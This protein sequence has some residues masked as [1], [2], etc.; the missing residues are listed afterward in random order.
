MMKLTNLYKVIIVELTKCEII[1]IKIIEEETNVFNLSCDPFPYYVANGILCHNCD[2][3]YSYS[4]GKYMTVSQVMG[5]IRSLNCK[6]VCIT[7]GEPLM[8]E[9]EV[10][11]LCE[12]LIREKYEIS[13]ETNGSKSFTNLPPEVMISM[14][15]KCPSSKMAEKMNFNLI[16]LL[17]PTDQLK[18]VITDKNDYNY[19]IFTLNIYKPKSIVYFM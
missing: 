9:K 2:T 4:D 16:S 8:Q 10:S 6:I 17:K 14:D 13:I 5:K 18:F 11:E 19:A 12:I 3:T 1:D 7:G 15:I